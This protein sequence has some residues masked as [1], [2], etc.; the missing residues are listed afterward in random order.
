MLQKLVLHICRIARDAGEEILRI[1]ENYDD[2]NVESKKDN[3]P[4][5]IADQRANDIIVKGLKELDEGFPIVS[6]ENKQIPYSERKGFK[7]F[8]LV[9]PLDGTKEFIKRNGEFTVNIALID[10]GYPVLGVIYVPVSKAL[11][12]GYKGHGAFKAMGGKTEKLQAS[13][14]GMKDKNLRVVC[15][16]SHINE[17]TQKF[18]DELHQPTTVAV[19]S[20]LKFVILAE[21]EAQ[22]YP[23]IGPTMEWDIG[24]AQA[25]L[26]EAG[27][28]VLNYETRNRLDYNKESLLNPNFIAYGRLR[29]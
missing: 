5:T 2:F 7:K 25:I 1:Y 27:G 11:Y 22:L 28:Q 21:G 3:S 18:M 14:F 4:L 17:A 12:Y 9:D 8:W 13:E 10:N 26:E 15:S 16:R 23:R 29:Q 19:G 24:A 20:S 6:E